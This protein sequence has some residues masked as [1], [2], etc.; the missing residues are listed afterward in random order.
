ME[1]AKVIG[2][3]VSTCKDELIAGFKL[4]LLE[5]INPDDL[6]PKS[7]NIVGVDM[8]DAGVG[9]IVLVVRGSSARLAT[10]LANR[11]VDATIVAVIDE[12]IVRDNTVYK[13]SR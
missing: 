12:I 1:V 10:G 8:V 4:L 9:D 2:T 6:S 11:P 3:V 5:T 13:K 7:Q